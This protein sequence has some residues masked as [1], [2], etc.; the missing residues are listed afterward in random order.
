MRSRPAW[1]ISLIQIYY[2]VWGHVCPS[3]QFTNE[4]LSTILK[5]FMLKLG[6]FYSDEGG[7][8]LW[9]QYPLKVKEMYCF[10][11]SAAWQH[12]TYKHPAHLD[13]DINTS[14]TTRWILLKFWRGEGHPKRK[15]WHYLKEKH[16][17][18]KSTLSVTLIPQNLLGWL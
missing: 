14:K 2:W 7:K 3:L 1:I 6:F 9:V 11:R 16:S 10:Q 4:V 8:V 5:N 12:A 13:C 15:T 18:G 17:T